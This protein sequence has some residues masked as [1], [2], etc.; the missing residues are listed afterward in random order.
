MNYSMHEDDYN[1]MDAVRAQLSFV[2]ELLCSS[3]SNASNFGAQD[4][5][6]FLCAQFDALQGIKDAMDARYELE[7]NN[8][9]MRW[10][11]WTDLI[12]IMQGDSH[13]TPQNAE[14]RI[15]D[16]LK[17]AALIDKDFE[18]VFNAYR[19]ALPGIVADG[20]ADKPKKPAPRKRD[21]LL[22]AATV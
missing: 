3:G 6:A 10:F 7:K 9:A 21:K 15:Y 12:K 18:R 14:K 20:F 8:D 4:L 17:A 1:K 2:S 22:A 16:K 5:N 11:D 19:D 13:H